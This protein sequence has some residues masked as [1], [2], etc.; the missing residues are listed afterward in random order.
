[1]HAAICDFIADCLQN[2]VEANSSYI[3][4]SYNQKNNIIATIIEDNGKGM[5]KEQLEKVRD[6]FYTDGTKHVRRKVGLGI[7]FLLQA[8]NLS[9]GTFDLWSEKGVGT[10]LEFSFNI[11]N[12]D[13]P[14][15]G[16]IC[17]AVLQ[18]MMFDG[19]YELEFVRTYNPNGIHEDQYIIKR[20]ELLDTLG[21]LTTADTITLAKQFFESQE[22]NLNKEAV[23][24]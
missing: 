23:N 7:P 20:S 17:F 12:I 16:D 9:G 18:A 5:T 22:E 1:M 2:S 6:P 14:P 3:K 13:T 24:G 11:S 4:L 15:E 10:K 8:L 21:D 19:D